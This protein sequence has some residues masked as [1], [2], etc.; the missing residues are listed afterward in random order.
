MKTTPMSILLISQTF[1]HSVIS[2]VRV[3]QFLSYSVVTVSV[4]GSLFWIPLNNLFGI[5]SAYTNSSH[6]K[7][8]GVSEVF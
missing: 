8:R 1:Q 4:I 2:H 3:L 7:S 5:P 6:N